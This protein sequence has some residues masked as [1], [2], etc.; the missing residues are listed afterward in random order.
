MLL[1]EKYASMKM[2]VS[3]RLWH[4]EHCSCGQKFDS[5]DAMGELF[6]ALQAW[7]VNTLQCLRTLEGHEDNVRVLAVG[8][9]YLF[10]GSW[11]KTVRVWSVDTLEC[12]KVELEMTLLLLWTTEVERAVM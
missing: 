2:V 10:S 4:I 1:F 7:D 5:V 6:F 11:D 3:L 8:R 9:G 12:T